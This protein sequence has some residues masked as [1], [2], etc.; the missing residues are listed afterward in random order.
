MRSVLRRLAATIGVALLAT[1]PLIT[2]V[3]T[4]HAAAQTTTIDFNNAGQPYFGVP[5]TTGIATFTGGAISGDLAGEGYYLTATGFTSP[6]GVITIDFASPVSNFTV[7]VRPA[8]LDHPDITVSSDTG[9]SQVAG[10]WGWGYP[11][12]IPI[13]LDGT[14]IQQVTIRTAP[15]AWAYFQIDNVGFATDA[16]PPE[17]NLT[18]APDPVLQ[19]LTAVATFNATDAE[20]EITARTCDPSFAVDTSTVGTFTITCGATSAGGESAA[21]YTYTVLSPAQ[22]IANLQGDVMADVPAKTASSLVSLLDSATKSLDKGDAA[23]AID[24]LTSV[25]AQVDAQAG[26]KIMI[27]VAAELVGQAEML[28]DSIEASSS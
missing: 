6:E 7:D 28:I 8:A 23:G 15:G 21:S 2:V 19:G 22:G 11:Y 14:G 3:G 17:V 9:L 25:I 10:G 16:T 24:K 26:K 20:S 4:A 27:D 1:V 5:Y 12:T 18:V 13:T